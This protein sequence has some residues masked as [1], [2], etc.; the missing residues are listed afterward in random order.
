MLEGI[1]DRFLQIDPQQESMPIA[2]RIVEMICNDAE[3]HNR[4][5]GMSQAASRD[6]SIDA[7][8]LSLRSQDGVL[9]ADAFNAQFESGRETLCN[10]LLQHLKGAAISKKS[11]NLIPE[12]LRAA[13]RQAHYADQVLLSDLQEFVLELSFGS[14]RMFML[15]TAKGRQ[16]GTPLPSLA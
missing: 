2:N 6:T 13:I 15:P 1:P 14:W 8:L 11:V 12:V 16:S 9:K 3:L 5:E 10:S 7:L 4:V